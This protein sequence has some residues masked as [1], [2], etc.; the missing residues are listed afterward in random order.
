MQRG[1]RMHDS[2]IL[3]R[4][5]AFGARIERLR[6]SL[7]DLDIMVDDAGRDLDAALVRLRA[8]VR[9]RDAAVRD[10]LAAIE[11]PEAA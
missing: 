11:A 9:E 1:N 2:T 10:L 3:H 4:H 6:D 8:A 7:I 5:V